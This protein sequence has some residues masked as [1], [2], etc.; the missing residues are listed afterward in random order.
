M[1]SVDED[2]DGFQTWEWDD[3]EGEDAEED[4]GED[5][6]QGEDDADKSQDHVPEPTRKEFHP[7]LTGE[8]HE[9]SRS[10]CSIALC[11]G[12]ICDEH[13]VYIPEESL[14]PPLEHDNDPDDWGTFDSKHQF[15]TGDFLF[16]KDQ[17]SGGNIDTLMNLWSD[18]GATAP[19][20]NHDD[21]YNRIDAS[22]VGEAP[23]DDFT[24]SYNGELPEEHPEWMTQEYQGWFRD[25]V[26]LIRNLVA[27]PDFKD[28]FDYVPYHEYDAQEKH[29]FHNFMSGDWAWREAVHNLLPYDHHAG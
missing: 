29:R 7:Y 26:Q 19:F 8:C 18:S 27:N 12:R 14:P 6:D 10:V 11:A 4:E 15:E 25:P 13:G 24:L 28:E 3:D 17:M 2:E 22:S 20:R 1:D 16:R 21:L 9:N 5:A 23:W